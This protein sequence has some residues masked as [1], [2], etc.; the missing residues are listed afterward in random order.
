MLGLPD[1][2]AD[3]RKLRLFA[4]ACLRELWDWTDHRAFRRA[5]LLAERLADGLATRAEA[6]AAFVAAWP[7]RWEAVRSAAA[8]VATGPPENLAWGVGELARAVVDRVVR[9]G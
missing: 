6:A 9:L 8:G 3:E 7:P 4:C 5:V 1:R 2:G